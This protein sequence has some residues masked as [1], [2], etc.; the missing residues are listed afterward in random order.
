MKFSTIALHRLKKSHSN[1][2]PRFLVVGGVNTVLSYGIYFLLTMVTTFRIAYAIA[3]VTGIMI[4]YLLNL[5]YVFETTHSFKK[6]WLFLLVYLSQ[7]TSCF[8][9]LNFLVGLIKINPLIAPLFVA[10]TV[11]PITYLFTKNIVSP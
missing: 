8:F 3:F 1:L 9:A 7:F 11:M 5:F 4:S 2:Y 10:I 6:C